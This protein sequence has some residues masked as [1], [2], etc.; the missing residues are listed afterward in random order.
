[1]SNFVYIINPNAE[2]EAMFLGEGWVITSN[3]F[4]ADL[5]QFTGG[6]DVS[7]SYYGEAVHPKTCTTAVRDMVELEFYKTCFKEGI[8][9]A[10]ICRGGQF[11]HV[12]NGGDMWQH[13][14]THDVYHGHKVEDVE[15]GVVF[16]ATSTH[17]Q[18]MRVSD[19]GKLLLVGSPCKELIK[20][21]MSKDG[22]V[23]DVLCSTDVEAMYYEATKCLCFQP[24]PEFTEVGE[25]CRRYYFRKLE[26]YFG[27]K[28]Q[29]V[30]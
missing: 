18:M 26:E 11:L 15:T 3:I 10:G 6:A 1:M 23:E 25:P 14:Y 17:H 20:Q 30:G 4:E 12:M 19:Y 9:M 21:H 13:C 7:P 27:L 2:Y 28:Q 5:V 8:P 24:H 29:V 22:E 16:H